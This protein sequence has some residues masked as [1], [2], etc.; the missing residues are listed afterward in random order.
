[1]TRPSS[2]R[3][4]ASALL[5]SAALGLG[6][7]Y[8]NVPASNTA[9]IPVPPIQLTAVINGAQERPTSTTST[10]SG[11]FTGTID[12]TSRVM[13]YTVTYTGITPSAGHIHQVTL[14]NGNGPVVYPFAS[15]ASPIIGTTPTMN[16]SRVDS[17][18][19]GFFYVNLHT[20]AF[21]AGEIRGDIKV[22]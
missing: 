3:W 10:A 2:L 17:I 15:L 6:S 8:E 11:T 20:P 4:L 22:R 9:P 16:Q 13:S 19:N 21:P 12:Q 7:C 1:M 18:R 5:I 14:A